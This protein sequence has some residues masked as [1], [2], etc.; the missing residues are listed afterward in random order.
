M[1]L[2][3][4][5]GF[6][7][8]DDGYELLKWDD[9]FSTLYVT[10]DTGYGKDSGWGMRIGSL[11][12]GY[13]AKNL[14]AQK[15][16]III[17]TRI[18]FDS[19]SSSSS[20]LYFLDSTSVQVSVRAHTDGSVN[21]YR[22]TTTIIAS[23]ATGLISTGTWYY[24]EFKITFDNTTGTVDVKLDG[25]S[26]IS[27]TSLDTCATS[28]EYI[29]SI[30]IRS[31]G[32]YVYFDDLYIC[33]TT[34][35]IRNDFLGDVEIKTY[36]PNADG[37]YTGLTPSTGSD[38]YA[39]VDEPQLVGETDY[40]YGSAIGDKDTY[41][42]TTYSESGNVLGVQ[43]CAAVRNSSTGT[44]KVRTMCRSGTTP[45]DNEGADF[46]ISQTMKGALTIYEQEPTD[47]VDW[48]AAKINAAEF[49]LKISS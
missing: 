5:D 46:A 30:Q 23:S 38:H 43:I 49:G 24:I 21:V 37:T 39:L 11:A 45:T 12:S 36:Y 7:H 34:G 33:D 27:A 42:M 18:K 41:D 14:P 31:N 35:S 13:L 3:F 29:T 10:Y 22:S 15:A 20:F 8:V 6:G 32:N 1:A 2:L 28:N 17:G 26:I 4:F 19:L 9:W 48:T 47:T 44:M 40:N 16:I 25:T